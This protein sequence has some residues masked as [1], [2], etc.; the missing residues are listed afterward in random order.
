VDFDV[1]KGVEYKKP[2]SITEKGF[3][4]V[5]NNGSTV[6]SPDAIRSFQLRIKPKVCKKEK[7]QNDT[8]F[9]P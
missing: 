7:K 6:L 9:S 4:I 8:A 1:A 3:Y 2:F 5:E